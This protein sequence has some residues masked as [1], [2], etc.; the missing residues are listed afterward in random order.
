M[1]LAGQHKGMDDDRFLPFL[2]AIRILNFLQSEQV[3]SPVYLFENTYPSQPSQYPLVDD[4]AKMV[5]PILGAPIVL[6]AAGMGSAAHRIRLFW[7][8]WCRQEVLQLAIPEDIH[9]RR[10]FCIPIMFPPP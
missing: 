8:N 6:D 1:S 3:T 5:E 4:A 7:T 9:H 2:D 10:K